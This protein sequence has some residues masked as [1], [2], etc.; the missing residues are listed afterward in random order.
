M[1]LIPRVD[2]KTGSAVLGA[3]GAREEHGKGARS[4]QRVSE[5][6]SHGNFS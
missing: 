4:M 5:A 3:L 1:A 6:G 2:P